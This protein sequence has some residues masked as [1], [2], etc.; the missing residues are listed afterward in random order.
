MHA[1]FPSAVQ[2]AALV[3]PAGQSAHLLHLLLLLLK[4]GQSESRLTW[5][6]FFPHPLLP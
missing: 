4:P 5:Y 3:V 1:S 2:P 6:W